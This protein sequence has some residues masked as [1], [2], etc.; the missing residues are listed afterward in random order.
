MTVTAFPEARPT[1][2]RR[3]VRATAV[4][5]LRPRAICDA[6]LLIGS[7]SFDLS[8]KFDCQPCRFGERSIETVSAA[9]VILRLPQFVG[10]A[11]AVFGVKL[12]PLLALDP[13]LGWIVGPLKVNCLF[14]FEQRQIFAAVVLIVKPL[15]GHPLPLGFVLS[16]AQASTATAAENAQ[17]IFSGAIYGARV[18][19]HCFATLRAC[20]FHRSFGG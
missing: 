3:F 13:R 8:V 18:L 17:P 6:D 1:P 4:L 10:W 20:D 9:T 15:F 19:V 12:C 11:P 14:P 5:R 2:F 16:S 7:P